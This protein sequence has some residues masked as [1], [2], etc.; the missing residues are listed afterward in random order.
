MATIQIPLTRAQRR[1]GPAL[2]LLL[3]GLVLASGLAWPGRG[4]LAVA[5]LLGGLAGW[6][7]HLA[8]RA[9]SLRLDPDRRLH[10]ERADGAALVA[11]RIRPG[12][13]APALLSARLESDAGETCDLLLPGWGVAPDRH[14]QA[15]RLLLA[16]REAPA[17]A[18]ENP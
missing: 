7:R 2:V 6:Q 12:V 8:R 3:S 15:R 14:R 11:D 9:V 1:A 16:A 4:L 18:G 13:V 10:C 17:A 5:V